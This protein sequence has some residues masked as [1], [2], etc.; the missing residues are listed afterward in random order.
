MQKI[1]ELLFQR[2]TENKQQVEDFFAKHFSKQSANFYNSCDLRNSGFKIA[3]VDTNCFPAGFNNLSP[4]SVEIAKKVAGNFLEKYFPDAKK[5]IIVPENHTRNLRYLENILA[6]KKIISQNKE[7][8]IGSLLDEIKVKTTIDISDSSKIELEPL[9]LKDGKIS[10]IDGFVADLVILN[11]DLTD[12]IP[13][14]LENT[15]TPIIPTIDLGWYKRIK[16]DHFTIYNQLAKELAEILK[17]DS[18][19]IST[20]HESCDDVNFK[21]QKGM[22]CLVEYVDS[23]ILKIKEK[24]QEYNIK[25]EPYVYV[26]ADNGTYGMAIWAVNS[27]K[28]ILEINKKNRNKM[29]TIKGSVQNTK[30]MIQEGVRT[31]D[32]INNNFAE[33]MIYSIDG[34]IV[35]NL[36]R[37]NETRD[38]KTSL[39]A[40]GATFFDLAKLDDSQINLGLEKEKISVVY[41]L[42]AKLASLASSYEIK[43]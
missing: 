18:W 13:K 38:E 33:P 28:E 9:C 8:I 34:S 17:I 24:Y 27:G 21:E 10:T 16:S 36:F 7:V 39:N 42:V 11:N 6:L 14:I 4:D 19:L 5:I 43:K 20:I 40:T 32:K 31:I 30:I 12:G 37:V 3:P 2:I 22:S 23:T 29:S 41:E 35:G 26:K 1:S 15:V 25:D